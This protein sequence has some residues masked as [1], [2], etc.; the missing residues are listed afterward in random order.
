[1]MDTH[2][3]GQ[4]FLPSGLTDI[5]LTN[6]WR[7]GLAFRCLGRCMDYSRCLVPQGA[8]ARQE[9]RKDFRTGMLQGLTP[10]GH[11]KTKTLSGG[12]SGCCEH[13]CVQRKRWFFFSI[14]IVQ[15]GQNWFKNLYGWREG[16]VWKSPWDIC[17]C[18]LT[19]LFL[20]CLGSF[21]PKHTHHLE[22]SKNS[23]VHSLG[24]TDQ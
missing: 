19:L 3:E 8:G 7:K 14:K 17:P 6:S 16:L 13:G 24:N 23:K 15:C 9:F 10:S 4:L 1:M 12:E 18:L 22:G 20:F 2:Q 21:S 5:P 11:G